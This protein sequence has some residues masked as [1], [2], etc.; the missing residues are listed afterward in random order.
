[1]TDLREAMRAL[2]RQ[3]EPDAARLAR[4]RRLSRRPR[5]AP[6]VLATALAAA[7]LCL[8]WPRSVP[9]HAGPLTT[10]ALTDDV[11][12][13]ADGTGLVHGDAG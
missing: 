8:A 9:L 1:M 4:V 13:V 7:V 10:G 6:F 12:I 5:R 3:T 2:R 11:A